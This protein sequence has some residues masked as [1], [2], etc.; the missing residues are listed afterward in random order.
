MDSAFRAVL[1]VPIIALVCAG[2]GSAATAETHAAT[3]HAAR[4]TI[5]LKPGRYTFRLG[6]RVHVGDEIACVTQSGSPAGGG[7]IPKPGHGVASSTG[8]SLSVSGSGGIK[9]ACPAH[10][11]SL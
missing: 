8:F 7:F 3:A 6:Q 4:R 5:T 2:C 11:S 1:S 9:I 10:P